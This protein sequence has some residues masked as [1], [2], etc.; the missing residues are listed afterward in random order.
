M[1]KLLK[2]FIKQVILEDIPPKE[3]HVKIEWY[4]GCPNYNFAQEIMKSGYL[5]SNIERSTYQGDAEEPRK[6][7]DYITQ[8]LNTAL[9]Y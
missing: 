7:K 6:N 9:S 2:E 5:E 1:S 8:N 4:H 3:E